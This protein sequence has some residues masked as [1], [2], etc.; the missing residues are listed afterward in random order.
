MNI[1]PWL[2]DIEN[3][4]VLDMP[5]VLCLPDDHNNAIKY[6]VGVLDVTKGPIDQNLQQHLQG[7]QAG[8]NDVAD[9][10]R[11]GQFVGLKTKTKREETF[12]F[13]SNY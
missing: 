12:A 5:E 11:V 3:I 2:D 10:Q 8:E 4:D 1:Q 13:G 7:E 9:L 6:I